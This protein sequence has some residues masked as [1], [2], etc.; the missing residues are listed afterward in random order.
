MQNY[1]NLL[2]REDERE[3]LRLCASEGIGGHAVVA[4]RARQAGAAVDRRAADRAGEDRSRSASRGLR[5]D[6]GGHRQGDRRSDHEIAGERG[7]PP[8]QIALAWLLRKPAVT[9][10]IV[11]ATRRRSIS[12]MRSRRCR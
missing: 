11:G 3:M 6:D 2:Y 1:Y 12:R 4:A 10:P 7:V 5:Q 8:A 9:S